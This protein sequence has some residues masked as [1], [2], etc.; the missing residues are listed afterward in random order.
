MSDASPPAS[1]PRVVPLTRETLQD[2]VHRQIRNLILDG[3]MSPGETVT[4]HGL[5]EAFGVSPMPVREALNR[6]TS[7][8]A[9]TVISGRSVGIPPLSRARLTELRNVRVEIEALA[10]AWGVAGATEAD[11]AAARSQLAV[12][13]SSIS[14]GDLKRYLRAN[15]AFHFTIYRASGSDIL[16]RIVEDLWLQISPYFHKLHG[17]YATANDHHCEMMGALAAR[18]EGAI[19]QALRADIDAAYRTLAPQLD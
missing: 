9:L 10:A 16:M 6:L 8:N 17:S 12:L 11:V 14:S 13:R 15:H 2:Q 1:A 18:D 4:I 7:A 19:Q 3:A 5:A